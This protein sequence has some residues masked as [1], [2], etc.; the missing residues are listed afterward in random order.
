M[1]L[2]ECRNGQVGGRT[3]AGRTD[4]TTDLSIVRIHAD[5]ADNDHDNLNDEYIVLK[6][7]G[8]DALDVS[9]WS[10]AD[11]AGHSYL[12][13]SRVSLEPGE[14]VTLYTGNGSDSTSELYWGSD[15]AVWN[16]GGD[17]IIVRDAD[18]DEMIRQ[19]YSG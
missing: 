14:T 9:G 15:S 13:P 10:V 16:N 7:S 2:W 4:G 3:T 6:N 19:T 11:D 12:V 8:N 1:G 18:G 5:A 17:T